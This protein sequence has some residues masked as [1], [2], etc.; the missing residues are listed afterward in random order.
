MLSHN[1]K[2]HRSQHCK[3]ISNQKKLY[4]SQHDIF[5][6]CKTRKNTYS[7]KQAKSEIGFESAWKI[8]QQTIKNSQSGTK[9]TFQT[10]TPKRYDTD[11][12][13]INNT[14]EFANSVIENIL[15][16]DKAKSEQVIENLKK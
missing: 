15:K 4:L 3:E 16:N 10:K 1:S 9:L 5:R 14:N 2:L 6:E 8:N 7:K 13:F 11:S 12:T